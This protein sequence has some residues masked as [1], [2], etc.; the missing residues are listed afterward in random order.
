MS[1][2]IQTQTVALPPLL[3]QTNRVK[4]VQRARAAAIVNPKASAA[5]QAQQKKEN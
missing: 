5:N 1:A 3:S 4:V 2:V